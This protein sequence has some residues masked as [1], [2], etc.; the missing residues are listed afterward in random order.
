MSYLDFIEGIHNIIGKAVK[1]G[2]ETLE[3][4]RD[5]RMSDDELDASLLWHTIC[6]LSWKVDYCL[7]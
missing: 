1:V 4:R 3:L 7:S 5:S 6:A 2:Q